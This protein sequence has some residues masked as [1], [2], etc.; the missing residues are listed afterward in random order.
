MTFLTKGG[1]IKKVA[2]KQYQVTERGRAF[3]A[4]HPEEIS[5][6]DLEAIPQRAGQR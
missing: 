6:R 3:L 5:T 2:P 4:A 1:L